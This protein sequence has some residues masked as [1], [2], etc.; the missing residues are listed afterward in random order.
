MDK[1]QAENVQLKAENAELKTTNVK[2]KARVTELEGQLQHAAEAQGTLLT[3]VGGLNVVAV[4]AAQRAHVAESMQR[5]TNQIHNLEAKIKAFEEEAQAL[6]SENNSLRT[7]NKALDERCKL[8][9]EANQ[10]LESH[11]KSLQS[12]VK[13][14]EADVLN[15]KT[16]F[17]TRD[18]M[19]DLEWF[20]CNE[21]VLAAGWTKSQIRK[22]KVRATPTR[23]CCVRARV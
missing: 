5:N 18:A 3:A 7:R 17:E 8:L 2:L 14:L 19:R 20:I 13:S 4:D 21:A 23:V 15:I 9:E 22:K 10:Q 12:R 16:C 11:V 1:L 6:R